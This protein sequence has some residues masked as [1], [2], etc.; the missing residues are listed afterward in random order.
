MSVLINIYF[1]KRYHGRSK[2][3]KIDFL[4]RYLHKTVILMLHAAAFM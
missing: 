4:T 3:I 1:V 2:V